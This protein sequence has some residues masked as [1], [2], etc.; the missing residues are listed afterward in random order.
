MDSIC[1]FANIKKDST[2]YY[3]CRKSPWETSVQ[4]Y[5]V[6]FGDLLS[7]VEGTVSTMKGVK[8]CGG[9]HQFDGGIQYPS[10]LWMMFSIVN[11]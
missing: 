1:V 6:V 10:V 3:S 2:M 11:G 9:Y 7:T 4:Y 5:G 8:Y